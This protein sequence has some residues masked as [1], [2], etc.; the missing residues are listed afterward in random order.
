MLQLWD[1]GTLCEGLQDERQGQRGKEETKARDRSKA[2]ARWQKGEGKKGLG[3]FGRF[4]GGRAGEQNDRGYQGQCWTCGKTGHK[5]S[6]CPWG[7]DN[8]DEDDV[9]E[10]D[11]YSSSSGRRSGDQPESEKG[12]DVGREWI[13]GNLEELEDEETVSEGSEYC[14]MEEGTGRPEC[15]SKYW[16]QIRA[17]QRDG[18]SGSRADQ[19]DGFSNIPA[20]RLDSVKFVQISVM[21]K[22]V[23][24]SATDPEKFVQTNVIDSVKFV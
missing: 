20:D 9:D 7:V 11:R 4:K 19:R 6:E 8:V 1:D 13:V 18:F 15:R 10:V 2:K 12:S 23:Q 17:D 24:V 22:F 21:V 16:A 3:K 14:E 5:S